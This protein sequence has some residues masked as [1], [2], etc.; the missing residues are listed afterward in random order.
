MRTEQNRMSPCKFAGPPIEVSDQPA[1]LRSLIRV[2]DGRS[3]G[4]LSSA[5]NKDSDQTVWMP[6]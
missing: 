4:N 2:F 1:H 3:M 6:F 5:D